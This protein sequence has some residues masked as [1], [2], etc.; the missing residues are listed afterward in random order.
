MTEDEVQKDEDA[1]AQDEA[2]LNSSLRHQ[3]KRLGCLSHTLQL[4][5]GHFDKFR[6]QKGQPPVFSKIIKEAKILVGK[7]NK[8]TIATP[9]L[10]NDAGMKLLGDCSTRWSSTYLLLERL[11]RLRIYVTQICEQQNWDN[12][13]RKSVV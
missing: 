8:S 13:D 9:L 3:I 10:I 6:N 12:L 5:L 11:V 4:V 2:D 1:F 7:F